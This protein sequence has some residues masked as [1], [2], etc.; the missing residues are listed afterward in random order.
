MQALNDIDF[1]GFLDPIGGLRLTVAL[2]SVSLQE[3]VHQVLTQ[4]VQ[5]PFQLALTHLLGFGR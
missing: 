2:L 5:L 1:V 3:L 4:S